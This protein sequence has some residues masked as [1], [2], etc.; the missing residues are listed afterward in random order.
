MATDLNLGN[1]LNESQSTQLN[2]YRWEVVVGVRSTPPNCGRK[3][4]RCAAP[5]ALLPTRRAA[6]MSSGLV[7]LC[8]VAFVP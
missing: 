3:G 8:R 1:I 7:C 2:I 5:C 6:Y 4:A